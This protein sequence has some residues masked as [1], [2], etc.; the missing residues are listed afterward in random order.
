MKGVNK[1]MEKIIAFANQKG[2]VAKTTS[3]HNIG[4]AIADQGKKVL[5]IDLDSQA[6]LTL[7]VGFEP[8]QL[9][10]NIVN[11]LD[12]NPCDIGECIYVIK[13]NLHIITS[14]ID[15]AGLEMQMLSRTSRENI[16][17]RALEQ[18][19][20]N[21]DYILIDCP[22][23][24]SILTINALSCADGVVIPTKTDYLSYRGIK[25]LLESI[26]EVKEYINP[27]LEVLGTI[28]TMYNMRSK[29]DNFILDGLKENYKVLG[30]V[31]MLVSAKKGIY[32]GKAVI[33]KEP[34]N[35]ISLEY[36]K[37]ANM[38]I[39]YYEGDDL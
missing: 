23:Q 35:E 38:L 37:I 16:L 33:E 34:D 31:K 5:L 36:K 8:L 39:Q 24:L 11:V 29:D 28:A 4:V 17:K 12:K 20:N 27:K 7:S 2:G 30:V 22:P 6:S 25:Q 14:V 13:D 32:E 19:R 15:L 10:K 9:E 1:K 26:N 3:T 18:I 21:Y